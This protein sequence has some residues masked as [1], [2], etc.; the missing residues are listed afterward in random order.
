VEVTL[1]GPGE[2]PILTRGLLTSQARAHRTILKSNLRNLGGSIRILGST[3]LLGLALN[4]LG[5]GQVLG[6]KLLGRKVVVKSD[7]RNQV[8]SVLLKSRGEENAERIH[9]SCL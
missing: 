2:A 3:R 7:A 8:N 9:L 5:A 6:D 1:V 4:S